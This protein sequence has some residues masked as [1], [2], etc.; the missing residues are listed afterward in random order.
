MKIFK[1][2]VHTIEVENSSWKNK[3]II[4]LKINSKMF[5]KSIRYI[6]KISTWFQPAISTISTWIFNMYFNLN[7]TWNRPDGL[8]ESLNVLKR[9]DVKY[10]TSG[11]YIP[12]DDSCVL[13]LDPQLDQ[14]SGEFLK[15]SAEL[16]E[17]QRV[18]SSWIQVEN[19]VVKFEE[20]SS[21]KFWNNFFIGWIPSD[22][23]SHRISFRI[24]MVS[25]PLTWWHTLMELMPNY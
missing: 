1:L 25:M 12:V 4:M 9:T 22:A 13:K 2:K 6:H 5:E 17:R 8:P 11:N 16:T 10:L 3:L 14:D 7:S 21:W 18:I 20:I 15:F 23:L 24:I 19:L